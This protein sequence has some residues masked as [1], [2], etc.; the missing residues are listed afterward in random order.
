MKQTWL[1]S[2][3]CWEA[4]LFIVHQCW[5]TISNSQIWLH[6]YVVEDPPDHFFFFNYPKAVWVQTALSS[7]VYIVLLRVHY[8]KE[9]I[10][11]SWSHDHFAVRIDINN[12]VWDHEQYETFNYKMT[13]EVFFHCNHACLFRILSLVSRMNNLF[14]LVSCKWLYSL[15]LG[16][17]PTH[18]LP[19][20]MCKLITCIPTNHCSL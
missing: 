11:T 4:L 20:S 10:M 13:L 1:F 9:S 8:K 5:S 15:L 17:I 14:L 7:I 3:F 18:K 6:K 19:I 2:L 16:A 12:L